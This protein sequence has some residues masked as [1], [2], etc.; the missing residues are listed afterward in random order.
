MRL[1]L[2]AMIRRRQGAAAPELLFYGGTNFQTM[3]QEGVSGAQGKTR[4]RPLVGVNI[5]FVATGC[6]ESRYACM[7]L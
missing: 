5:C 7:R 3:D 1:P 4:L 6:S 2:R